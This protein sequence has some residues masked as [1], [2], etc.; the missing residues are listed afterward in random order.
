[1]RKFIKQQFEIPYNFDKN[2]IDILSKLVDKNSIYC[3]YVPAFFEDYKGVS[4]NFN[5]VQTITTMTRE[6]YVE[7]IKYIDK[8]FPGKV[9]LLLQR[10]DIIL[11]RAEL[12]FYFDL[13]ITKFCVGTLEQ[14]KILKE[15]NA[16]FDILSSITMQIIPE[17]IQSEEFQ[18]YFDGFVLFFNYTRDIELIKSLP[19]GLKYVLIVNSYCT[20]KCDGCH[21]WFADPSD[22]AKNL[23][24][25][26]KNLYPQTWDIKTTISPL[27]LD[28]FI[29]YISIFK[30]QGREWSTYQIIQDLMLYTANFND[31]TPYKANEELYI[32]KEN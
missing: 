10:D 7:H 24:F 9:Q 14:A 29:P 27:D 6:A 28:V 31:Y 32:R 13:N 4:R 8:H 20:T 2:L 30:L 1:M 22:I 19:K 25:C 26:P 23:I 16:D 18:K 5:S 21:H 3:I 12:Q 17:E 11:H 15:I